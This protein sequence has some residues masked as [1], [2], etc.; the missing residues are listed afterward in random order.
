MIALINDVVGR[1]IEA[2]V[3][4]FA[5]DGEHDGAHLLANARALQRLAGHARARAHLDLLDIEGQ[6]LGHGGVEEVDGVRPHEGL[7]DA[8]ICS[9]EPCLVAKLRR[10]VKASKTNAQSPATGT[11]L[12]T[13]FCTRLW[14]RL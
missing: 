8:K 2:R 12:S 7:R 13:I 10:Q 4:A 6:L 11:S 3:R 5:P 1:G 14:W 9:M